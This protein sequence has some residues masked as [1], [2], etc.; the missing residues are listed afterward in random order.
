MADALYD[1][2]RQAFAGGAINLGT[3]AIKV[4]PIT[5]GYTP[6]LANHQYLSDLGANTL[7]TAAAITFTSDTAGVYKGT[8]PSPT[9]TNVPAGTV[10]YLAIYKD[11]GVAGTSPLLALIDGTR[12]ITVSAA[13]TGS[14]YTSIPVDPLPV[15]IPTGKSFTI[16]GS[17]GPVTTSGTNA[18]G[19]RA[20]NVTST[21]VTGIA[22]GAT[23]AA[24]Y[25]SGLP[26]TSNGTSFSITITPDATNGWFKL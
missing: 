14:P 3:D 5:A 17:S 12:T 16:S 1:K 11:T 6:D 24:D 7:G 23:A 20:L 25:G 4:V 8:V 15:A 2:G 19:S 9:Y 22:A 26:I 21:A 10:K 13:P 18:A